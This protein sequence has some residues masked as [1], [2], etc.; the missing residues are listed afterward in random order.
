V[1]AAAREKAQE[2]QQQGIRGV[3]LYLST[4]G[5]VLSIVSQNWPVLTSEVDEN[6][7]DP[8]PLRPDMALDVAREEIVALR[9]QGLLLGRTVEFDHI[10]DWYIIAW[11]AF[12][13]QQF[14]ADEARKLAIALGLDIEKDLVSAKRVITKKQQF[15]EFQLPTARRK[16]GMVDPEVDYFDCWLDAVHT[17]MLVYE[18]DGAPA[19]GR[20]LNASGLRGDDTFKACLLALLNAIPR[21]K[22]KGKLLRKEAELLEALRLAFFEDLEPPVEEEAPQ[23]AVQVSFSDLDEEGLEEDEAGLNEDEESEGD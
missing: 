15:V 7:G 19:C 10:T 23:D 6:T 13:A 22:A 14:P 3:D 1:R 12:R 21:T 16:R 2:F 5:P 8:L 11:D 20:F 18:E 9:K 4:F 17:A